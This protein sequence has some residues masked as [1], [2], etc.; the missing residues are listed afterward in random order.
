MRKWV[1]LGIVLAAIS[2]Q[3]AWA[4]KPEGLFIKPGETVAFRVVDGQPANAHPIGADDTLAEGEIKASFSPDGEMLG[5]RNHSGT[6]LNYQAFIARK[7]DDKGKRTSVCTLVPDIA[8]FENW[9]G[10]L[11][12]IRLANFTPAGEGMICA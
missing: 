9:P 6:S 10:G 2:A 3:P 1:K 4:E 5:V 11:P 12:G 7:A 8:V